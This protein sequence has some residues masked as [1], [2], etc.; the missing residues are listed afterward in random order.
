[1]EESSVVLN[2]SLS[3]CQP[4]VAVE[5]LALGVPCLTG[6]LALGVLDEHPSQRL[7]QLIDVGSLVPVRAGLEKLLDFQAGSGSVLAEMMDDYRAI[8]RS[9]A[10]ARLSEFVS[11]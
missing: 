11:G 9:A 4:M 7:V 1:M 2:P 8:L 5:S 3:E 10:L 6:P